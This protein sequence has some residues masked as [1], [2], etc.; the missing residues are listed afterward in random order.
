MAQQ[1]TPRIHNA[2]HDDAIWRQTINY[3]IN[4]A[5]NWENHWGF[6]RDAMMQENEK[7]SIKL[8]KIPLK[9][10]GSGLPSMLPNGLKDDNNPVVE[11][12]LL[13]FHVPR[14]IQHRYPHQKYHVPC[15]T[16]QEVGW[17]WIQQPGKKMPAPRTL[18][19]FGKH[20]RGRGDV[21]EW[22]GAAEA[23]P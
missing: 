4:T 7:Q 6:M 2:V 11:D 9:Q 8:P 10:E 12:W 17:P 20:A 16:S 19:R 23:L 1:K 18:E 3:E 21:L 13:A 22:F 15:T 5:K 14:V